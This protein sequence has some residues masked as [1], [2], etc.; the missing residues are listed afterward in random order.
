MRTRHRLDQQ[1]Q[2]PYGDSGRT[3][4][5]LAEGLPVVLMEALA[6]RRPILSTCV[7]GIPELVIPGANGWLFEAGS[8]EELA[9]KALT[10]PMPTETNAAQSALGRL[11]HA[12]E[13]WATLS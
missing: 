5:R 13:F 3:R 2:G 1:Q 9:F 10:I 11:P 7:A 4:A 8:I 6:L 12:P